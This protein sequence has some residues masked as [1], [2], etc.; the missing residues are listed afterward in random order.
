M[1]LTRALVSALLAP[2]LAAPAAATWSV[3]V[4]DTVTREVAVACATCIEDI[5][6]LPRLPALRPGLGAGNVQAWW[7][8]D[9]K[10]RKRMWD[11]FG[12]GETPAEILDALRNPAY[13]YGIANMFG[14]PVSYTGAGA[15]DGVCNVTGQVGSLRYAIQGNVIA[16]EAVCLEAE[17]ALISTDG[18]L[19]T[20]VMAAMEA[21]RSMG[22]D[23]RCSCSFADPDGCGTPPPGTWK[24]AHT[25]FLALAR[26]GDDESP[27][28]SNGCPD[29]PIYLARTVFGDAGDVDPILALQQ[30][31]DQWRDKQKG[32]PDHLLSEVGVDRAQ[33]VAD[34][35]SRARVDVVLR[36]IDGVQLPAGGAI[37]TVERPVGDPIAAPGPVTD[38][39]DGTYSFELVAS[40]T[41]GRAQFSVSVD[42]GGNRPRLLWPFVT[43]ESDPLVDLHAGQWSLSASAAQPLALTLNRGAAESGRPYRLLLSAA[44][45]WPGIDLGAVVLPLNRDA[46]LEQAWLAPDPPVFVG[47][48][49]ALDVDGRA[50]AW[51]D[52]P[53][54]TLAALVGERLDLCAALGVPATDVTSLAS[55]WIVP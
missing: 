6:L 16:G 37:L 14:P 25:A 35:A 52:L 32:R 39:G 46:L 51:L 8:S 11:G 54:A 48:V 28:T 3:V 4:V 9:G 42:F 12:A 49:C 23:G 24:S 21:A 17:R 2:L 53:P 31:V 44:G 13:Q 10:K 7:D 45:N 15:Q 29:G 1:K 55:L 50:E 41:A 5:D 38:H 36:D 40:A 19:A 18:D 43:L 33:L 26:L 34:G 22:G 27:C 30:A 47:F 20:R